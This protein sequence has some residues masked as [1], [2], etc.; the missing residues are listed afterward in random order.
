MNPLAARL[1]QLAPAWGQNLL[2]TGFGMLLDREDVYPVREPR[3]SCLR[4]LLELP[5]FRG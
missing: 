5:W 2:L 1:Y 4:E 3:V